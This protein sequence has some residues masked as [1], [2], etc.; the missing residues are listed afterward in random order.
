MKKFS[1]QTLDLGDTSS[2]YLKYFVYIQ[3]KCKSS[4]IFIKAIDPS[5]RDNLSTMTSSGSLISIEIE[6]ASARSSKYCTRTLSPA[7][8]IGA[9][10]YSSRSAAIAFSLGKKGR[11]S[12][13]ARGHVSL[14]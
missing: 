3:H 8:I 4:S 12:A 10:N 5:I 11:L 7:G 9:A 2:R 1:I 14:E 13:R 6:F